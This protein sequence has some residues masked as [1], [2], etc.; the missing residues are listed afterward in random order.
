VVHFAGGVTVE[1]IFLRCRAKIGTWRQFT[2]GDFQPSALLP[3]PSV[4][5]GL[6]LTLA[7]AVDWKEFDGAEVAVGRVSEAEPF[8]VYQ[9]MWVFP[10]GSSEREKMVRS[11]ADHGTSCEKYHM[12]PSIREFLCGIDVVLGLRAS[13]EIVTRVRAGLTD[14]PILW[15]GDTC[16]LWDDV[17]EEAPLP[18]L[19]WAVRVPGGT[20]P[21]FPLDCQV[22]RTCAASS[23]RA[24]FRWGS[25]PSWVR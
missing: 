11:G 6:F 5:K 18:D 16:L 1:E 12:R 21:A 9:H 25:S 23:R 20:G 8:R 15:A 7:R 24:L 10:V 19:H 3:P 17:S 13:P 4:A 22:D 14:G 2:T